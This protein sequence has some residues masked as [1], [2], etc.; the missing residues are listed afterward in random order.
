MRGQQRSGDIS[1]IGALHQAKE[2]SIQWRHLVVRHDMDISYLEAALFYVFISQQKCHYQRVLQRRKGRRT[3]PQTSL[4]TQLKQFAFHQQH[5]KVHTAAVLQNMSAQ[6]Q[7]KA[8][9]LFYK[10]L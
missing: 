8:E 1:H 5:H 2:E 6:E 3:D 10:S 9:L 7:L 4:V